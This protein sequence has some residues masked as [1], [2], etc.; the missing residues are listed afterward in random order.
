MTPEWR[1]I[2][3]HNPLV[4]EGADPFTYIICTFHMIHV[5]S[6]LYKH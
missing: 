3:Y 4:T 1:Y 2:E 5:W 6:A